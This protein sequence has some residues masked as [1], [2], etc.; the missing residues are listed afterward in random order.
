MYYENHSRSM[1]A[2]K[3]VLEEENDTRWPSNS[4][5]KMKNWKW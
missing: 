2:G 4:Q 5:E 3:A 1:T